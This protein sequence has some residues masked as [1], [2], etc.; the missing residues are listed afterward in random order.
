VAVHRLNRRPSVRGAALL[1][2]VLTMLLYS[3]HPESAV[4]CVLVGILWGLFARPSL[5][6]ILFAAGSGVVALLV[7]A[8]PVLPFLEALRVSAQYSLREAQFVDQAPLVSLQTVLVRMSTAFLPYLHERYVPELEIGAVGSI[9]V[10][11]AVYAAVRVRHARYVGALAL[12]SLIVHSEWTPVVALLRHV[13]VLELALTDR[14]SFA[15]ALCAAVMAAMGVEE[16]LRRR[17]RGAP[18]ILGL[19]LAA[20]AIGNW[21]AT[22]TPLVSHAPLKFGQFKVLAELAGLALAL[23]L[24]MWRPRAA[25]FLGLIVAQRTIS[26]GGLHR[27]FSERQAYPRVPLLAGIDRDGEPFRI[28]AT[29]NVLIPQTATLYGLEDVRGVPSLTLR[30]YA[31]TF[32]LW[33][34]PQPV[35][36]Q[37]VD[38]L[39]RPF[40]S[41]LN[42]RYALSERPAPPGWKQ[43]A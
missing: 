4:L 24:A 3:G 28:V 9:V 10:A 15:F 39:G 38:D 16:M 26:D 19:V 22:H 29:G 37:R 14:L 20:I 43:I 32:P 7:A 36:F 35:W 13:P 31:E 1:A 21:W 5:R 6:S 17:D 30:A 2:F 33:C 25:L 27:S 23:P 12:F 41:F 34:K 11:L 40:L 42:V 8:V 18:A